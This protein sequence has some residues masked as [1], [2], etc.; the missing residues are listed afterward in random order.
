MVN[1]NQIM[2]LIGSMTNPKQAIN[3]MLSKLPPQ[4]ASY[5]KELMKSKSP[6]QAILQSAKEGKI[7]LEQFNTAKGLY[8]MA[9]KVGLKIDIPADTWNEA[10]S[11]LKQSQS[12]SNISDFKRF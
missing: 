2:S 3:F 9:K 8:T 6:Q 12:S 1:F 10:E 7:S 4:T 11:L 5:I